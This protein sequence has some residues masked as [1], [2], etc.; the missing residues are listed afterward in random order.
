M[1]EAEDG[2]RTETAEKARS[3]VTIHNDSPKLGLAKAKTSE[4]PCPTLRHRGMETGISETSKRVPNFSFATQR[5]KQ[6]SFY[7][8]QGI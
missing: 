7:F 8:R 2:K 3:A 6:E 4:I 5:G 1:Q